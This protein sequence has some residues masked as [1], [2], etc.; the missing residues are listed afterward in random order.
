MEFFVRIRNWIRSLFSL[1]RCHSDLDDEIACHI[2]MRMEQLEAE[3]MSPGEAR[4]QAMREFGNLDY[5]KEGCRDAWGLSVVVGVVREIRFGIRLS[6]R[7]MS[8]SI[9]GVIVLGV[10]LAISMVGL[11]VFGKL[12]SIVSTGGVKIDDRCV[13]LNWEVGKARGEPIKALDFVSL[14]EEAESLDEVIGFRRTKGSVY[15]L[16]KKEDVKQYACVHASPNLFEIIDV[17]PQR[18]RTFLE[19]ATDSE[20]RREVVISD[21]LWRDLFSRAES[22]V[23][24][25]LVVNGEERM[26]VGVMPAGFAFPIDCHFWLPTDWSRYASDKRR[27]APSLKVFGLMREGESPGSVSAELDTI[28]ANLSTEYPDSNDKLERVRVS[29][30]WQWMMVRGAWVP[31]AI[32]AGIC[33][34]SLLLACSNAFNIIIARTAARSHELAIRTSLGARRSHLI[35]QVI[36]DGL[37]LAG[38]GVLLGIA[39]AAVSIRFIADVLS[40]F[41]ALYVA[42]DLSLNPQ[43]VV[44]ACMLAVGAGAA[45]SFIPAWRASKLD[46]NEVLKDDSKSSSSVYI[47]WLSKVIV[48]S[49]VAFTTVLLFFGLIFLIIVPDKA[50]QSLSLPYNEEAVLTAQINLRKDSAFRGVG[51]EALQRFYSRF[52]EEMNRVPGVVGT[53]ITSRQ[54]GILGDGSRMMIEGWEDVEHE[55]IVNVNTVS[56][57]AFRLYDA[58]LL[59]GRLLNDLDLR[60]SG[61]VC[62][63]DSVF[64]DAYCSHE[65]PIG[66]RIK[67]RGNSRSATDWFTVVGVIE[68][69]EFGTLG[70]TKKGSVYVSYKQIPIWNPEILVMANDAGD[71]KY[72]QAFRGILNDLAPEAE[73]EQGILTIA[74]RLEIAF[75]LWYRALTAGGVL[76]GAVLAMALIGLYSIVAFATS[77]RRKEFGIRMAVGSNRLGVVKTV[78]RP[79]LVTVATGLVLGFG[80]LVLT[81][82]IVLAM[83]GQDPSGA[84]Y[85]DFAG[86]IGRIYLWVVALV[87]VC[88]AVGMGLP[89]WRATQVD[90]M[91]VMRAE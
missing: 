28:A 49:Q 1:G 51:P 4:K 70:G 60:N 86:G 38:G 27:N 80:V 47:G 30:L 66:M 55:M 57:D 24:G 63:V 65:E 79:W 44:I 59:E 8:S 20:I 76:G 58:A 72:R 90:P 56:P 89:A 42:H 68:D 35:R 19:N 78:L 74:E 7:Y 16:G 9:L 12:E 81:W 84:D 5:M 33:L 29:T 91:K 46:A 26:I 18:G 14:K 71:S 54:W 62:V 34:L 40:S 83:N 69:L 32:G 43:V 17:R 6:A 52:R 22:A 15:A 37:I 73:I 67:W 31:I 82:R 45:A 85:V 36:V 21:M 25:M 61:N 75:G 64:V 50:A 87:C 23:G 48:T 10:G 88:C 11:T 2:E 53:A 39:I 3:G 77:M 41:D 13:V